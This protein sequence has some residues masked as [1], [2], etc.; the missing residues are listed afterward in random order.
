MRPGIRL[1]E[2]ERINY[3]DR[4]RFGPVRDVIKRVAGSRPHEHRPSV[5][6]GV[7]GTEECIWSD[8]LAPVTKRVSPVELN[9]NPPVE[10]MAG[11]ERTA[12]TR[13]RG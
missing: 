2:P 3:Q 12:R 7:S 4:L 9:G 1:P 10:R 6:E 5:R 8:V 13:P 11:A